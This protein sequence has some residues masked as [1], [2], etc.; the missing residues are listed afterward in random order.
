MEKLEQGVIPW[1]RPWIDQG[2]P[3]N[4]VSKHDYK[5]INVFLLACQGYASPFWLSFKQVKEMGGHVKKGEKATM[6]IFWKQLDIKEVKE[7]GEV[8]KKVPC[9]RYYNVFNV[10][11]AEGI[12]KEKVP[13]LE[14]KPFNPIEACEKVVNQMPK[15]PVIQF[16]EL[17]AYYQPSSDAVNMPK[18]ETFESPEEYYSTLFHEL[19]HST[20][21][22]SR[23]DR[24]TIKDVSPFGSCNYSKEE[25]I[26]EMGS[27]FLCGH[28]KIENKT[29]D[30]SAGYIQGWLR[31][32]RN[33]K[34]MIVMAAS[35]AQK[36]A[37]FILD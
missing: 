2:L 17:R 22:E 31:K 34:K 16:R 1:H 12:P 35:Q 27:A 9:V 29:I 20:G 7:E 28:C 37:D 8:I 23:L 5:G 21:H 36:A 24:A 3:K 25:L 4:L 32:L 15:K 10:E 11:Q 33:D 26:A 18:A 19:S 14:T 30:N 6:V 13:K